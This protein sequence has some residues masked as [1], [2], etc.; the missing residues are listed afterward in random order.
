MDVEV[1]MVVVEF[2][3]TALRTAGEGIVLEL[4]KLD[5]AVGLSTP[6]IDTQT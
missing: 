1:V 5:D 2:S 4:G 3:D 6:T